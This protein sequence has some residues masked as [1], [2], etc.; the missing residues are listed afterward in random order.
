MTKIEV[1][2]K[3]HLCSPSKELKRAWA[4]YQGWGVLNRRWTTA[5]QRPESKAQ[6]RSIPKKAPT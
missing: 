4:A 6:L 2:K 5:N 3:A 1:C